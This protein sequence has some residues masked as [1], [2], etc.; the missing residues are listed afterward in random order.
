LK[1]LRKA[2]PNGGHK[3]HLKDNLFR[4]EIPVQIRAVAFSLTTSQA[5]AFKPLL[6]L[7]SR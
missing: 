3:A 2:A 1:Q 6:P 7:P 5:K 4:K